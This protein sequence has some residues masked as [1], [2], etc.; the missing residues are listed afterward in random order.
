MIDYFSDRRIKR[1]DRIHE[2]LEMQLKASAERARFSSIV[3]ADDAGFVVACA[4]NQTI[5]EHL[6]AMSPKLASGLKT[7]HGKVLTNRGRVRLSVAPMRFDD[8]FLYL[9]AT[10]GVGSEIPRELFTSGR[11]VVRI[12]AG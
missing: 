12:L 1:S 5:S 9:S 11:G 8:S 10:E 3:L 7:W 4:G 6:A 2:A